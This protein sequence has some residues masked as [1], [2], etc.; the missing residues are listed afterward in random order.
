[1]PAEAFAEMLRSGKRLARPAAKRE[2]VSP[3]R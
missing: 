3:L 2:A 1:V